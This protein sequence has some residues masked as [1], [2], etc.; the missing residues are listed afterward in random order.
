MLAVDSSGTVVCYETEDSFGRPQAMASERLALLHAMTAWRYEPFLRDGTAVPAIVR[1][2]I[3]EQRLPQR[4]RPMP[5]VPL[6][7]VAISLQRTGCFGFCPAYSVEIRGDGSATYDG[8]G[9]VDVEGVHHYEVPPEQVAY[10]VQDIGRKDLWSMDGSYRAP[11]T[12]IPTYVLTLR[13]GDQTHQIEDY[14]GSMVGMPQAIREFQDQ[15]DQVAQTE[16]WIRLSGAAVD[17]LQQEGFDF[18]SPAA[19]DLLVRAVDNDKGEDER[20]ILRLIEYGAPLRG[21]KSNNFFETHADQS[22]LDK[23]LEN[24]RL[25]LIAPLIERGALETKGALDQSKLDAAFRSAIRGG[26]LDAVQA[27]WDQ[28]ERGKRPSLFFRDEFDDAEHPRKQ[29]SPATLLLSRRYGDE[30]WEGKRIAQWLSAQG[31]DLKAHGASGT[32]LLH[33]AVDSRDIAFVQYLLE[34]GLDVNAPGEFDLPALGSAT[35][36]DIALVLLQAGSEW[37]MGD[38]GSGF[39]RYARDQRWGRVLAWLEHRH[40]PLPPGGGTNE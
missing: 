15:V 28:G 31:C 6:D 17:R 22:L 9:F 12:D 40:G 7:Q 4:R 20:A 1:E 14:M 16:A 30:G 10:L 21:G 11:I 5:E 3:H 18:R 35:D 24:H 27:I 26:R 37:S 36:E 8:Q 39:L 33:I 38:G 2:Q 19:A 13:L 25:L 32:T 23:A 29:D 34:Q